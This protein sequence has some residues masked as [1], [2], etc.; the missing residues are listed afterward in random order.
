M[1]TRYRD[2]ATRRHHHRGGLGVGVVVVLIGALL[3]L[4][5]LGIFFIRDLFQYWPAILIAVG[6]VKAVDARDTGGQIAGGVLALA[7]TWLLADRL[8]FIYFSFHQFW[9][10]LLIGLGILL[11]WK[12]SYAAAPDPNQDQTYVG[13]LNEHL[14]FAGSRRQV[15]TDNFTGGRVDAIFGGCELDLRNAGMV[16]DEAVL[17]INAVFGGVE[18]T[19]PENWSVS[20]ERH[21]GAS[22]LAFGAFEDKTRQ[23]APGTPGMKRL[24]LTGSAVFGGVTVK[25]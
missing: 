10:V 13:S 12:H 8:G 22:P 21:A 3:L 20:F 1:E 2:Y 11:I 7:G 16:A 23:P 25:N 17:F 15:N 19:I 4:N 9:P 5:N 24:I 6:L 18:I 14:I